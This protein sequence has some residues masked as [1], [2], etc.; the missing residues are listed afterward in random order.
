MYQSHDGQ[1][2]AHVANGEEGAAEDENDPVRVGAP[3]V[4]EQA[5]RDN[6]GTD[7][8]RREAV[9]W[10]LNAVETHHPGNVP[11]GEVT[12]GELNDSQTNGEI[13]VGE[14]A[15]PGGEV[16]VVFVDEAECCKDEDEVALSDSGV[17]GKQQDDGGLNE[18]LGWT[19]PG[20]FENG[21]DLG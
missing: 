2:G 11:V 6:E 4:G 3:A 15:S 21:D 1:I 12:E 9:F 18:H 5:E 16:V 13:E 7:E 17:Y 20:A 8:E 10:L 19:E 14:S